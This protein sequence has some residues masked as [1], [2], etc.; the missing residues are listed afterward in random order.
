MDISLYW[1]TMKLFQSVPKLFPFRSETY[2]CLGQYCYYSIPYNLYLGIWHVYVQGFRVIWQAYLDTFLGPLWMAILPETKI[3]KKPKH[4][5]LQ[6]FY[7]V[8]ISMAAYI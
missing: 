5:L 6:I 1:S 8:P 4:Q 2:L 3:F 7:V